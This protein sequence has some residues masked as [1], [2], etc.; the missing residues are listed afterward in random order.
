MSPAHALTATSETGAEEL[1]RIVRVLNQ[2]AE[3]ALDP[4]S[5]AELIAIVR[6]CWASPW[7]IFLDQLTLDERR[8]AAQHGKLSDECNARLDKELT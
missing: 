7:D 5:S 1:R 2:C 6:A 3:S 8:Y 4:F